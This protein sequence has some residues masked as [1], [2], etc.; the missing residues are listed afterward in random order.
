[1]SAFRV[2]IAG[3]GMVGVS[4]ALALSRRVPA[5]EVLLVESF[6]LPVTSSTSRSTHRPLPIRCQ[7]SGVSLPSSNCWFGTNPVPLA[8]SSL[9]ASTE[10]RVTNT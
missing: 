9:S 5:C 3:G 4:L 2:V 7:W 6:P 8:K 1:M 10:A